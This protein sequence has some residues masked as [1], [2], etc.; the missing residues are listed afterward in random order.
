M[1]NRTPTPFKI[2]KSNACTFVVGVVASIK[3]AFILIMKKG[4]LIKLITPLLA[5]ESLKTVIMKEML[6]HT[7]IMLF[8]NFYF[9]L[10]RLTYTAA[11]AIT[12]NFTNSKNSTAFNRINFINSDFVSFDYYRPNRCKRSYAWES[13]DRVLMPD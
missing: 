3:K 11:N 4:L 6:L 2:D 12:L 7:T 5:Q 13:D 1:T 9:S 8:N 10:V